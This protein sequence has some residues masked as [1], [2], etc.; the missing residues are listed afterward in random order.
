MTNVV[1]FFRDGLANILTGRGTLVDR[2]V[3]NVWTQ[4][5]WSQDQVAAAYRSSWLHRK[6]VDIPAQDMV[7]A[8]RDWDAS[9]AEIAAIEGEERRLG[10]WAKL[11]QALTL[12]RL[13][14][15]AILIGL[16]DD[17]ARP[18]PAILHPGQLRYL[19]VL[20]RH[21]LGL[22]DMV[23][24]PVDPLFGQ[25]RHFRLAGSASPVD[26]HPSRVVCFHGLPVPRIAGISWEER[27]WGDAVI[28]AVDE[29]VQHATTAAAG[30]A[31]LIDE[32]KIDVF[33]FDQ[34]AAQLA[35]PDGEARVQQRTEL[36]QSAK[37]IH[38]AIILDKED[39]WET[40]QINW[41]GMRDIVVTYD[42]RVAGAAD[43]P[44]TRLF[45]KAPDGMNATGDGDL[46]NYFQG[47]AA[48]QEMDLRPAMERLDAVLLPSAGVAPERSWAFSPLMVLGAAEQAEI[49]NR[50]ADTLAKLAGTG[51]FAGAALEAA[52]SNRMV[53]SQRW[54]GYE[55]ARGVAVRATA[56]SKAE[57]GS[58]KIDVGAE[59]ASGP[60]PA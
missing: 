37:S 26:I 15:G 44:A 45:G 51:L 38:R 4:R 32:A 30:F 16:G 58:T 33:R 49:E 56:A 22:G 12:G 28:Q 53:E 43:I 55:G 50:E 42:G 52:F 21:Q 18:L 59:E 6:I 2:S 54:P 7:R 13:G 14:G 8:G 1:S 36:T 39:A 24:D 20:S 25:P 10:L 23:T 5:A 47:I 3:H 60:L 19:T 29:A 27:F 11:R 57:K 31:A 46:T 17:P 35:Q 40:R 34:L 48:R 9:E 41:A